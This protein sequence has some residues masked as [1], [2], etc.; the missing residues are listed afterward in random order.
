MRD[1]GLVTEIQSNNDIRIIPLL[2]D[3]CIGCTSTTCATH[4]HSFFVSNPKVLEI[5]VGSQ[6]RIRA[7]LL[8]QIMQAIFNFCL[9]I[10][11]TVLTY[12]L[13][14]NYSNL[15]LGSIAGISLIVL[16]T[17]CT[18]ILIISQK[19]PLKKGEITEVLDNKQPVFTVH[20]KCKFHK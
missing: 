7:P 1:I 15:S 16:F 5:K 12:I 19:I 4:G 2:K 6:V 14:F 18:I 17:L 13:L 8:H 10:A 20:Q 3:T 9:P 11:L